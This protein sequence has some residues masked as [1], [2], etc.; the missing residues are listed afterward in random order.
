MQPAFSLSLSRVPWNVF[1]THTF[2]GEKAPSEDTQ[3]REVKDFLR[4]VAQVELIPFRC[5]KWVIR[6]ETGEVGGRLHI[7]SL[8]VVSPNNLG[9]FAV[10]KGK[11]SVASKVWRRAGRKHGIAT[12]RKIHGVGDEAVLY[13]IKEIDTGSDVYELAKT[14][15]S[16][17]LLVSDTALRM[18]RGRRQ[19]RSDEGHE[20]NTLAE[21][22]GM[23]TIGSA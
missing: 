16:Q 14:G 6:L 21:Y 7:H 15:A 18:M 10:P 20:S 19:A 12:F 2:K 13:T 4:W 5:L 23:A 1:G 3:I 22:S 11:R 17:R 8:F 9:L